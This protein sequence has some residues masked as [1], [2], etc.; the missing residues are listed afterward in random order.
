MFHSRSLFLGHKDMD[1]QRRVEKGLTEGSI[2]SSIWKLAAPMMIGGALQNLFSMVDLYFVGRL[3]YLQVAALSISGTIVAILMM[4]VMGIGVGTTALVA[5]FTG[6][7][8]PE[9]ADRVMGQTLLL[10]LIGSAIMLVIALAFVEPLL[11]LFGATGDILIFAAEYLRITFGWSITIFFFVGINQAL[12]GSGDAKTP[13]K[14]LIIA[15][16]INIVLDPVLI[17]GY[18]P[19]PQMGVAGSAIATVFSRGVGFLFLLRHTIFG[20]ST[21]HFKLK[22]LKPEPTVIKHIVNIGLFASMQVFIREISFLLLMRLVASFGAVT[23]AAYG[24]GSRLR[25]FIMVPGFGFANSAA[26]LAGQNL[27]AQQPERAAKSAWQAVL[28]YECIATPLAALFIIFAPQ[29]IAF[30]TDNTAVIGLGASFLRYVG[31]TIPFLAISLI[32][33]QA[34]N[35]AGDTRTPTIVQF[36]GQLLFRVPFAYFL[37]LVVGMGATGIWLGINLSDIAT[38]AGTA[39]CF[40]SGRWKKVYGKHR[41]LLERKTLTTIHEAKLPVSK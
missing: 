29:L 3:G 20:F 34:M 41:R 25:M 40:H 4:F 15:N 38:G 14:A 16:I 31:L 11:Y 13:L 1:R 8:K 23:I 32:L 37:S 5:H 27:G 39:L 19:F 9:H 30:F 12:R 21:L 18:G 26:V 36:A 24:I 17:M 10:G 33:S 35:G 2:A 7:K 28:F 6:D 22:Y